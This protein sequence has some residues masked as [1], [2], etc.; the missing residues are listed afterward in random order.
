M[1]ESK[2]KNICN[3]ME[4]AKVLGSLSNRPTVDTANNTQPRTKQIL[5]YLLKKIILFISK[6]YKKIKPI[7]PMTKKNIIITP[8]VTF[9]N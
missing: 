4:T 2:P 9:Y 8:T 3:D 7:Q 1:D 5:K 6:I